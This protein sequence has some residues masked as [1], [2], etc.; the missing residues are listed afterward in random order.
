MVLG[1]ERRIGGDLV[2]ALEEAWETIRVEHRDVPAVVIVTGQGSS[3]RRGSPLRLG[4]F[5]A[6]RWQPG[7][8]E[9]AEVMVGGEGLVRGGRDV[10]G[11]L[12]HEAAHAL[13]AERKIN[14]TS[15]EGRYHNRRFKALAEELGLTVERHELLGWAITEVSA[16]TAGAYAP[17]IAALERAIVA[18]RDREQPRGERE[19]PA[20]AVMAICDCGRRIR[21]ARSVLARGPIVCGVCSQPFSANT[22]H[23]QTAI[24]A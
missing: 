11:T 18:Y 14:D 17:T 4:Q 6:A 21:I 15:R 19:R 20:G 7:A 3:R 5:A 10:L 12:L 8:G 23:Q 9:L 13:A 16:S 22:T 1:A 2:R 24:E